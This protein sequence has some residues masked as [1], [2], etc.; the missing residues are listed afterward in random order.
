MGHRFYSYVLMGSGKVW[1]VR[2]ASQ[3][4]HVKPGLPVFWE[5]KRLAH[6]EPPVVTS[7]APVAFL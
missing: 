6:C 5:R 3:S 2:A 4:E 7:G 1:L